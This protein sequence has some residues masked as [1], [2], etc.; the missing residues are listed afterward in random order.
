MLQ[1]MQQ[2]D[3]SGAP[4]IK[5]LRPWKT[6]S[7]PAYTA[8]GERIPNESREIRIAHADREV[9]RTRGGDPR[10]PLG[11]SMN[12]GQPGISRSGSRRYGDVEPSVLQHAV[13][14]GNAEDYKV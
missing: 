11:S 8:A 2:A 4:P 10:W 9:M 13:D 5:D 1:M 3:S 6:V 12:P 7:I 14:R